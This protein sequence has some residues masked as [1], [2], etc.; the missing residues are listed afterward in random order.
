MPDTFPG[1]GFERIITQNLPVIAQ[2]LAR[3][4]ASRSGGHSPFEHIASDF[5]RQ[6]FDSDRLPTRTPPIFPLHNS[7]RD[8]F[9]QS[10][11][12]RVSRGQS[13]AQLAAAL[14]RASRRYL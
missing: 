8:A 13:M 3:I 6:N 14:S 7:A 11:P 10:T 4:I 1:D 9:A 5:L 2:S 12:F